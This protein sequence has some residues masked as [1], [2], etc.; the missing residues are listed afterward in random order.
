V[1]RSIALPLGILLIPVAPATAQVTKPTRSP[2]ERLPAPEQITARQ[3][4]DGSIQVTWRSVDGATSY[5][6]T[7]SVPPSPAVKL[8]L[9]NP[10]DTSYR[11]GDV[12][13]GSTYYYLV[14]A[15]NEAGMMGLRASAPPVTAQ[16]PTDLKPPEPPRNVVASQRGEIAEVSWGSSANAARYIAEMS[17]GA[18]T[19]GN[20]WMRLAEPRCCFLGYQLENIAP[21]THIQFRVIAEGRTGY[22]S[23]PATSNEIVISRQV[24]D[25][26]AGSQPADSGTAGGHTSD[27]GTV[28]TTTVRPAVVPPA[29]RLKV[30]ASLEVGKKPVFTSLRLQKVRWV[31]L[32]DARAT[33]DARGKVVGRSVGVTYVIATG[34][35]P[36]GAVGSLVQRVDVTRR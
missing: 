22:H 12:Q 3:Q 2:T 19:A 26:A 5:T 25:T 27:S 9:P 7:R 28:A 34:L 17:S 29:A 21:G 32:D 36:Q 6:V 8:N 13:P 10:S 31:S 1:F 16:H 11:D 18:T 15:I 30:G 35:T 4:P 33:V 20:R 24:G 14:G 23:T